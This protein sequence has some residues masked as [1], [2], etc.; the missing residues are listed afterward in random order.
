MAVNLQQDAG[1]K[2]LVIKLTGK[3][4]KE[5]YEHFVPELNRLV[6]QHGQIRLMVLFSSARLVG[7]GLAA[8]LAA[9]LLLTRLLE[10]ELYGVK[11]ADPST[12]V[13]VSV[14]LSA[15][16]LLASY[17]PARRATR[18]DPMLALREE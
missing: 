7:V 10:K 6:K 11:S 12:F 14:I 16:A 2:I 15:A 9:A 17:L 5:D 1:G 18:V 8:G 3:L 4:T 13:A